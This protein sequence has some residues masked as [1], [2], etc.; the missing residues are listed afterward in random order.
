M[1]SF[2]SLNTAWSRLSETA[3]HSY[4][5]GPFTVQISSNSKS[6]ENRLIRA[7]AHLPLGDGVPD[8]TIRLWDKPNLPSL[9]WSLIQTNGYRGYGDPPLYFH[10]FEAIG[11]LSAI[12]TEQNI[13]YYAIRD[14]DS[15]PWWVDGSPLQVILHV[16]FRE[17]GIQLTHSA[18]IGDTRSSI[19]LAGKG[20]SGKSTTVLACLEG[21]LKTL[22]EDYILVAPDRA[23]SIYHTAKWQPYTRTLFPSYET[24]I[25]NPNTSDRE[26]ALIYYKDLFPSQISLNSP[27]HAIV[28]LHIGTTSNLEKSDLFT[29]LQSLLLT[30]AMQ[31][32]LPDPRTTSLLRKFAEPLEHYRLSLGPDLKTN[33]SIL[34]SLL[35]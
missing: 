4:K 27:I 15:L 21:G 20:G 26:K 3:V 9:N 19:L 32:P 25:A 13:A 5:I 16:W 35:R 11:A 17:K 1:I 24:H 10:Y 2:D 18:A 34:T 7:F 29:S 22:G 14:P 8:L 23:Y 28:S 31:L 33:V 6:L 12:D 30:T